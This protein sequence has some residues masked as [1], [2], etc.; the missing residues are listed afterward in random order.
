MYLL[1][2]YHVLP[3]RDRF[4]QINFAEPPSHGVLTPGQPA[5]TLTLE[6]QEAGR[7]ASG[8][9]IFTSPV[10]LDRGFPRAKPRLPHP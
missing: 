4:L 10:W 7:A 9:H 3:Q 6:L 1:V 8:A 2:L 5:R